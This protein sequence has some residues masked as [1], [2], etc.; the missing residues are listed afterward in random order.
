M[1]KSLY[2]LLIS[3]HI[4]KLDVEQNQLYGLN[5]EVLKEIYGAY[6]TGPKPAKV[7]EKA[8]PR[9]SW[10]ESTRQFENPR[11]MFMSMDIEEFSMAFANQLKKLIKASPKVEKIAL[12]IDGLH[13]FDLKSYHMPE[14]IYEE[15]N[16]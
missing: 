5:I 9:G 6:H 15:L 13:K 4:L 16:F 11:T 1:L 10:R 7:L 14:E 2:Y 3:M 12:T 8:P